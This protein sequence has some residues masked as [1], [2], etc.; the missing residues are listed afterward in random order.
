MIASTFSTKFR[1]LPPSAAPL[2]PADI[3]A[4]LKAMAN[5]HE[6][7]DEL[8]EAVQK[9]FGVRHAFFATSGRAGLSAGLRA[10]RR[11]N[12]DRDEVL[13]PAYT[14]FS[15]PSAVVNAGLKVSLYDLQ[16]DTLAPDMESLE[17][18][19]GPRTLCVVACHLFGY[20]VDLKPIETLCRQHGAA[21]FD[22]AAQAMGASISGRMAGT[23]GDVGLFS[24]SRGK[25]MTAVDGG[26]VLTDRD[27][28]AEELS[29][30]LE[31]KRRAPVALVR[32]MANAL[33]LTV[34]LHPNAYWLPA[35][36]PFLNIGASIFDPVFEIDAL[37]VFRIG[38]AVSVLGR[39][40]AI[41][42]GRRKTTAFQLEVLSHVKNVRTI[43]PLP[44]AEPVFLRLPLLP[45]S[46]NWPCEYVPENHALG[47][48]RSYPLAIH[49]INTLKS[50]FSNDT[51]RFP[52]AS[53][54]AASMVTLPTHKYVKVKDIDLIINFLYDFHLI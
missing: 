11:L 9:K 18:A 6:A 8:R 20:P 49:E 1:M 12:P 51:W 52:V 22:D 32:N 31:K 39:L 44:E 37:D 40:D 47:V 23:M 15:V 45:D 38:I 54:L 16:A 27:D 4:G 5:P 24:L 53:Y 13:L 29:V 3:L 7:Q 30:I 19:M 25:N 28:L 34:L 35:S 50:Y 21:L 26:I 33:A 43:R 14:S 10:L 42:S 41:N 17:R 2:R 48:V 46:G 36:L